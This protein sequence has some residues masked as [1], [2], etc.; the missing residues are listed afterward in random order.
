MFYVLGFLTMCGCFYGAMYTSRLVWD[1]KD[2]PTVSPSGA[3]VGLCEV[4]GKASTSLDQH[5]QL[6]PLTRAPLSGSECVWFS[7]HLEEYKEDSDDKGSWNTVFKKS[8]SNGFRVVDGY[9]GIFVETDKAKKY[10]TVSVDKSTDKDFISRAISFKADDVKLKDFGAFQIDPRQDEIDKWQTSPDGIYMFHPVVGKWIP[11]TYVSPDKFKYFDADKQAWLD[12]YKPSALSGIGYKIGDAINSISNLVGAGNQRVT[13]MIV[14]PMQDIFVHGFLEFPSE[15]LNASELTVR[16]GRTKRS[17]FYVSSRG[18][19]GPLKT[20]KRVRTVLSVITLTVAFLLVLFS[21]SDITSFEEN[22]STRITK[23]VPSYMAIIYFVIFASVFF[24]FLKLGRTYNRFIK[25][26]Q[27]IN[28]SESTI[29]I[30]L[31]RRSTLI[32]QLKTVIDEAAQHEAQ[33]Q[34]MVA[35]MRNQQDED[36]IKSVFALKEAYPNLKTSENFMHLQLELGR[37]EEKIAMAR[38]FLIDSKLNYNN[39]RATF[40]GIIFTPI[41]K[42]V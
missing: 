3:I 26:K 1:I 27:Q 38:S 2:T 16:K 14:T 23:F 41:F 25:L 9:G 35:K 36:F 28:V 39:L 19:E 40:T 15:L 30:V 18:E 11:T 7:L 10:L 37:S 21:T 6:T 20:L 5:S 24:I 13:E 32:P 29:N 22:G 33:M 42:K 8:S 31:K 34:E 12:V 17:A 4:K